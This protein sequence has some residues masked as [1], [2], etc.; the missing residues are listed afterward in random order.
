MTLTLALYYL[1]RSMKSPLLLRS[2]S[3]NLFLFCLFISPLITKAQISGTVFRDFNAN[4]VKDNSTTYNEPFVPGVTVKA[5][6]GT[7]AQVGGTKTT[8]SNGAYSFSGLT[9]P[10]RIEF[11]GFQTSDYPAPVGP[12]NNSSVQFYSSATTTANFGLNYPANYC[13][14]T[15][16]NL[17]VPCYV[18]GDPLAGGA[19]GNRGVIVSLPYNSTGSSPTVSYLAT[20][21]QIG[22]VYGQALLRSTKNLFA[23]AFVK[24]HVGLGPGG[25]GA[26]YSINLNTDSVKLFTTLSAGTVPSAATRNLPNGTTSTISYDVAIYDLVGKT[27]LG[28][29]E[30]SDDEKTLYAV[31]LGDQKL[32]SIAINTPSDPTAGAVTSAAIPN[33]CSGGSFRPFALKYY[34]GKVYVGV[35]C[36]NEGSVDT[37]GMKATVYEFDGTNFNTVLSFPLTYTKGATNDAATVLKHWYPWSN[38]FYAAPY[39]FNGNGTIPSFPQPWFMGI[40]FDSNGSM[41]IALRDRFGDQGGW[42]NRGTNT[43]DTKTYPVISNGDLLRAGKCSTG[44]SWTIESGGSVCGSTPTASGSN[45]EGPGGGEFYWDNVFSHH[46]ESSTGSLALLNGTGEVVNTS[47]DPLIINSGGLRFFNNTNGTQNRTISTNKSGVQIYS[48]ADIFTFGKANGLGS[49]D[50]NCN[51]QPLEIGNRVWIDTNRNGIQDAGESGIAGVTVDLYEGSTKVGTTTTDVNGNYYFNSTN[52]NLGGVLGLKPDSSYQISIATSQTNVNGK[53]LTS[54]NSGSNT[55]IDNN[56]TP[57]GTNA[58]IPVTLGSAGQNDHSYD[59]GFIVCPTV[60]NPSAAQ[61]ICVGATGTNMTVNTSYNTANV[62]KFVKFTTKQMAGSTPTATEAT[63]I[64]AG[65]AI[66]TVTPTGVSSPY[67]A[68]YTFATSDFPNATSA[69]ITYYVYAILNPDLGMSCEPTQEIQV[70]INPIPSAPTVA[71]VAYCNG[72]PASALSTT[73]TNLLW[74]SSSTGGTGTS[75]APTPSTL[76]S[77]TTDYYVSQTVDGCESPRTKITVTVYALP[78]V[79]I[80]NL[81][82]AYC[83]NATAVTLSGTPTGGVFKIDGIVS[84]TFDP[85][86]LNDSSHT[87]IYT[88]TDVNGCSAT[89][90]QIE[91]VSPLL[92][93]SGSGVNATTIGGN[94]GSASVT[95][96]GGTLNYTYLWNTGATSA[97]IGNLTANKY[98]V[99]VTDANGCTATV[100]VMVNDPNCTLSATVIGTNEKCKNDNIGTATVNISGNNGAVTYLWSNGATTQR[101]SNL[102]AGK[103]T[104]TVTEAVNCQTTASYKVT[105]PTAI[106]LQLSSTSVTTSGGSDGTATVAVTGGIPPYIYFWSD[107]LHQTTSTAIN[108]KPGNYLVTVTD[109]NNCA[110]SD[111]P[112]ITIPGQVLSIG[113]YIWL[114]ANG[115][116]VQDV[117]EKPIQNVVLELYKNGVKVAT[118]ATDAN[119]L[120][121]FKDSIVKAGG[122][123]T[124]LMPN[125]TYKIKIAAA[126][127]SHALDTLLVTT[128]QTTLNGG[129]STN[130]SNGALNAIKDS[131]CAT[132]VTLAKGTDYTFDFGFI[133]NPSVSPCI[134]DAIVSQTDCNNNGTSSTTTDDYFTVTVNSTAQNGGASNKYEVVLNGTTVINAGGTTYSTPVTLGAS[135]G[136]FKADGLTTYS[137]TVRDI[138]NNACLTKA[139]VTKPVQSCSMQVCP[140]NVICTPVTVQRQK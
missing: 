63:A 95:A 40:E 28:E 104:V 31:N 133:P 81:N 75:T 16:P 73:G 68:T 132:V 88:Y 65:T 72:A 136:I 1:P 52:V 55:L 35:V 4:G 70:T 64:Y 118:T 58:I 87:V 120:Y 84:T 34:R 111:D 82:A 102:V 3:R 57:S 139:F 46:N 71:N 99:T 131:V 110:K 61:T 96:S 10:V 114:D 117:G 124:F 76:T 78:T 18:A 51:Q 138:D 23:A 125:T 11:S 19:S 74:Y 5:Y 13:N 66:A 97:S 112:P 83:K 30:I 24:R 7:N 94:D 20:A 115:N 14:S 22:S 56:A 100:T 116:G 126:Q 2:I 77:G 54:L 122:V 86:V 59:F 121:Y 92:T 137:I 128:T 17:I 45:G 60:T 32:Y 41:I 127:T 135:T 42:K 123:D 48:D 26:I 101:I 91:V 119:G 38:N 108:L 90:T 129:N 15:N 39:G 47:L 80:T 103:Y 36:T 85:S 113:D 29:L 140:P 6:D 21:K 49:I 37:A 9:L 89:A 134:I 109:S 62:I 25:A 67:T 106:A 69:P 44:N 93:A 12:G 8:D 43:S 33:P 105:E 130:D 107:P 98:T 53:V 27:G 50:L 79:A